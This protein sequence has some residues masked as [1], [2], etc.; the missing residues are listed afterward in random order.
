[1]AAATLPAY[2]ASARYGDSPSDP[3]PRVR[4]RSAYHD[5]DSIPDACPASSIGRGAVQELDQHLEC[6]CTASENGTRPVRTQN[7][8]PGG[9]KV[10]LVGAMA[11]NALV[12]GVP[13]IAPP[14]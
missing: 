8:A 9:L 3:L 1:M 6:P 4:Q 7:T 10:P 12:D 5:P 14:G 13:P 2:P 11:F